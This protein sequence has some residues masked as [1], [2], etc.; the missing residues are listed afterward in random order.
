MECQNTTEG[1]VTIHLVQSGL[2]IDIRSLRSLAQLYSTDAKRATT[3]NH[4]SM[5]E[6]A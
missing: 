3:W 2:S 6:Y 4:L 1:M 5:N